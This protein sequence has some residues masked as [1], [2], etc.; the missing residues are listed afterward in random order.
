MY[1]TTIFRADR[2]SNGTIQQCLDNGVLDK[3]MRS[4]DEIT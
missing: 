4:V 2:F 3:L 1:L